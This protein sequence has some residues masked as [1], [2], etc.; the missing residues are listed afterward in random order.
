MSGKIKV[1]FMI[2]IWSI[3]AIQMYVNYR[4]YENKA[5]TAFS[6]VD[7][8][9]SKETIKGYGYFETMKLGDVSRKRMLENLA[10]ELG[11]TDGYTFSSGA[12][13]GYTKMILTKKGK[14]ATT[15]LQIVSLMDGDDENAVPEQ[16]IAIEIETAESTKK[17]IDLYHKVQK[18]YDEM[19]VNGQVTIE[20]EAEKR[21]NY[22]STKGRGIY[23]DIFRQVSAKKVD[24]VMENG[25]CTV[26]GY[27]KK[28]DEHLVLKGEKVNLQV[29]LS[30]NESRD[31]TYIKIGMPIVNSSY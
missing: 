13:D 21:G 12:G 19:G 24:E 27:T 5:V 1:S 23:E 2:V 25:I 26:Y 8:Y 28:E 17:A 29:V 31:K 20:I 3:V 4:Q 6:V 15:T 9:V 22:V 14:H 16:Y 10:G 11:I 7:D 18:A 30:Y